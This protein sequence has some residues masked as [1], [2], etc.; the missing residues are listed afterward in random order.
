VSHLEEARGNVLL[1]GAFVLFGLGM[2]GSSVHLRRWRLGFRVA[3]ELGLRLRVFAR[4][5]GI[6]GNSV[7]ICP[8]L[9]NIDDTVL[10]S[11]VVVIY[12]CVLS[13]Q[14]PVDKTSP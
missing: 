11:A 7:W 6:M 13:M 14:T 3:L 10:R 4:G 12:K 2:F 5:I 9:C 8:I 1:E